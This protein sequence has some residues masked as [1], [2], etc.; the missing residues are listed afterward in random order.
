M[1]INETPHLV[2]EIAREIPDRLISFI[3]FLQDKITCARK[4]GIGEGEK[5]CGCEGERVHGNNLT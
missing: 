2:W 4:S 3:L 1:N 5:G